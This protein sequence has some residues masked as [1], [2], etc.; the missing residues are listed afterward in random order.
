MV[1]IEQVARC[2]LTAKNLMVGQNLQTVIVD[3]V[4]KEPSV[5]EAWEQKTATIPAK[6][7]TYSLELLAAITRLWTTIRCFS[8][9][10]GHNI[11]FQKSH[12][13]KH[14]TRKTLKAKGTE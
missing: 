8:F 13:V 10:Q 12:F 5:L 9:S 14:G 4:M 7:E 3:S 2:Y 6:Y 11:L 1:Q